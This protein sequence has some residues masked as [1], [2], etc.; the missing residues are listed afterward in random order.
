MKID[1]TLIHFEVE[2]SN[3]LRFENKILNFEKK[4]NKLKNL[5]CYQIEIGGNFIDISINLILLSV[6]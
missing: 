2:I 1:Q 3:I 4:I 5:K 6:S